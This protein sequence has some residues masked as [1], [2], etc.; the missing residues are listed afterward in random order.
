[1]ETKLTLNDAAQRVALLTAWKAFEQTHGSPDDI[2]AIERQMPR[3]V[4]KRRKLDE[5]R[6]EEYMDY[7]F[8]ADDESAANLSKLLQTAHQWKQQQQTGVP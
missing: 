6:Y 4:K 2:A 1:M 5:D 3:K 7:V 8:P